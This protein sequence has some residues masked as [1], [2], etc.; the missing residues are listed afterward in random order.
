MEVAEDVDKGREEEE[1]ERKEK[2]RKK[3][4]RRARPERA[5]TGDE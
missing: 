4:Y 5:D 3:G 2:Q 1:R